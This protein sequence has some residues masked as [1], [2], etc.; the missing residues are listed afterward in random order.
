MNRLDYKIIV[1]IIEPGSRVLDL[2]C[3]DGE[4]L[5]LLKEKKGCRASGIE[6]DEEEVVRAIERGVSVSHGDIGCDLDVYT[7]K[8][9]DYVVLNESLQQILDI[10]HILDESLRIGRYVIVGIPNFCHISARIQIFF[11]GQ[12]P[13]TKNLP[14]KWY[15]TPNLRFLSLRDFRS[16]CREKGITIRK[17]RYLAEGREVFFCTNL[18]ADRGIFVLTRG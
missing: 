6:I 10:E 12:V 15:N 11:Q 1:H 4:L 14:Y 3:G 7:D 18:L 9:F 5:A 16:F 8:R 2:G 17:T 13:V